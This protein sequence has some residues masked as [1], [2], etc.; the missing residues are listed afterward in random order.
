MVCVGHIRQSLSHQ[1]HCSV[2]RSPSSFLAVINFP[3]HFCSSTT[4]SIFDSR[5][6]LRQVF[7]LSP[8]TASP[9]S[10][11]QTGSGCLSCN[12]RPY[13]SAY[14]PASFV[15]DWYPLLSACSSNSL[16]I[17]MA[18]SLFWYSL[19]AALIFV[20]LCS[21]STERR[22][23]P[24]LSR[25]RMI[26]REGARPDHR[27]PTQILSGCTSQDYLLFLPKSLEHT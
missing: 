11:T 4:P 16:T 25:G 21:V 5:S 9:S 22:P 6:F 10:V 1:K 7:I 12:C 14:F 3:C 23:L 13:S 24:P 18:G 20:F 27:Q 8:G 15:I 19:T 2:L 26:I 17:F